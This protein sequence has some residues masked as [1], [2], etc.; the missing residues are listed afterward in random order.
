MKLMKILFGNPITNEQVLQGYEAHEDFEWNYGQHTALL[1]NGNLIMFDNGDG[2]YNQPTDM[3]IETDG[4]KKKFSRYVE[5]KIDEEN[6]TVQQIY[7]FG[8]DNPEVYSQIM[9][10]V[11]TLLNGN[12]FMFSSYQKILESDNIFSTYTEVDKESNIIFQM[13]IRQDNMV[14][15][16]G[17]PTYRIYH[18][19]PF[20]YVNVDYN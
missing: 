11:D 2:R 4:S 9:S 1:R 6:M 8:K 16:L 14:T 7:S 12:F 18:I 10:K 5:Y 13:E 3:F 20:D 15:P 17:A 19:N